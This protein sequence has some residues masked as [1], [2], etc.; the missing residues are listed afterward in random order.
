MNKPLMITRMHNLFE[1]KL[2][3]KVL[4]GMPKVTFIEVNSKMIWP[5]DMENILIL[6]DQN[7]KESLEM[8]YKKA[9]VKKNGSM[10]L[11][12]SEAIRME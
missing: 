8:M 4:S 6:M 7:I 12:M 1:T 11:N 9:M 2:K 3:A 5:T 10:V